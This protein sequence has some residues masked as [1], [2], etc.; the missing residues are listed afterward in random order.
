[1][2]NYSFFELW[3]DRPVDNDSIIVAPPGEIE[4]FTVV[5]ILGGARAEF[6]KTF[7]FQSYYFLWK[8]R[9]FY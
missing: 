3:Q 7:V 4:R 6:E 9:K 2:K 8:I 1:M 5:K